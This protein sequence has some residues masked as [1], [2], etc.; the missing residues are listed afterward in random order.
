VAVSCCVR[1][2]SPLEKENGT[3]LSQ[4]KTSKFVTKIINSVLIALLRSFIWKVRIWWLVKLVAR[5]R[6]RSMNCDTRSE[7]AGL[8]Q[9]R[10]IP[11]H[12]RQYLHWKNKCFPTPVQHLYLVILRQY[13]WLSKC[14]LFVCVDLTLGWGKCWR[15]MI[16]IFFPLECFGFKLDRSICEAITVHAFVLLVEQFLW[17][18]YLSGKME[19]KVRK[20]KMMPRHC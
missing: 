18:D 17:V 1:I 13:G 11:R 20:V 7:E 10:C 12:W 6:F 4:K 5:S 3:S 8:L 2:G 9:L 16:Y 19:G 15:E 14:V